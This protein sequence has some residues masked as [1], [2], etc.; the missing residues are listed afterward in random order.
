MAEREASVRAH[1][2]KQS[3]HVRRARGPQAPTRDGRCP[4][5]AAQLAA[6]HRVLR[7]GPVLQ[8]E[9]GGAAAGGQSAGARRAAGAHRTGLP[10][11]LKSG[12][13]ALSGIALDDV[14]VHYNSAGPAEL[15][16]LAYTQGTDIH[17]APGQE[18][19]L[20]HEAWH[21][22]QQKQ[23]RVKPT[24]QTKGGIGVNTDNA[25]EREADVMGD[26]A[27]RMRDARPESRLEA[28]PAAGA[29]IL[30]RR[31]VDRDPVVTETRNVA[32]CWKGGGAYADTPSVINGKDIPP[33]SNKQGLILSPDFNFIERKDQDS[34]HRY[35]L[36]LTV[37]TQQVGYRLELPTDGPWDLGKNVSV[38]EI[39]AFLENA[40]VNVPQRKEE[41]EEKQATL[42]VMPDGDLKGQIRK[43]EMHH[44]AEQAEAIAEVLKPWDKELEDSKEEVDKLV[45]RGSLELIALYEPIGPKESAQEIANALV[46][47]LEKK[48]KA[49]HATEEGQEPVLTRCE[50]DTSK[51]PWLYKI[52]LQLA[53]V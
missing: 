34:A 44:V 42:R 30:Q 22:V 2:T 15:Q 9:A 48:G 26:M 47:L 13:E 16:A 20:P 19:H 28:G 38:R 5:A 17:V 21:V 41:E 8:L 14:R 49:Y 35:R 23:G 29:S 45:G 37:P 18:R 4:G 1:F 10:D 46:A 52:W 25:L 36:E 3:A 32:L 31:V 24:L 51:D 7:H 11:R 27:N 12:V 50:L 40:R 6:V 53:K 33:T 43:H 39:E